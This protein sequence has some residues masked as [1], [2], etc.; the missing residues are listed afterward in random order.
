MINCWRKLKW[1]VEAK[2][3]YSSDLDSLGLQVAVCV[4]NQ[5]VS[6]SLWLTQE[7]CKDRL[8]DKNIT[9]PLVLYLVCSGAGKR[10][11]GI[12]ERGSYSR[13][14][15]TLDKQSF[16]IME[17]PT[18]Q[19]SVLRCRGSQHLCPS[20]GCWLLLWLSLAGGEDGWVSAQK[21][22]LGFFQGCLATSTSPWV[23]LCCKWGIHC[24]QSASH[25]SV[26]LL[27][28]TVP[29]MHPAFPKG[30]SF[31]FMLS[32]AVLLH[33]STERGFPSPRLLPSCFQ[34]HWLNRSNAGF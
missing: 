23:V 31:S 33:R 24:C 6:C 32:S 14:R 18:D 22:F 7:C 25:N 3:L 28:L 8:I 4:G 15:N 19:G 29:S 30:R 9:Q 26:I 10:S 13:N 21:L 12:S 17:I 20:D 1:G 27:C 5:K 16:L 11:H 34:H 2:V